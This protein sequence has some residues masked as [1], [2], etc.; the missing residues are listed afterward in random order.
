MSGRA[1]K[2]ADAFAYARSHPWI[3]VEAEMADAEHFA[4]RAAVLEASMRFRLSETALR[5]LAHTADTGREQ[6]PEL[7]ARA[8]E[9]FAGLAQV[10][11]AIALLPRFAGNADLIR[12]FDTY[13]SEAVLHSSPQSFR[14]KALRKARKLSPGSDPEAHADAFG[15]RRVIFEELADGMSCVHLFASTADAHAIKRRLTSTAK[16]TQRKSR[17]GASRDERTRDQ[18]RAD[19][20]VAWLRGAGTPTAVKTKVFVTVPLD[21][22]TP[23]AQATVRRQ[24]ADASVDTSAIDIATEPQLLGSGPIDATIA[25]QL[26]LD[27]GQF[28]RVITDPVSGVILDMDRRSRLVTRAQREWLMLTHHLCVRDGCNRVAIDA[29]IDHW[30]EYHG[31]ERG[32][33]NISNLHPLCEP[34]HRM[35]SKTKLRYRRRSDGSVGVASPTG[36]ATSVPWWREPRAVP[37]EAPF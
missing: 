29:E 34:D 3:Y 7:W 14:A 4:E 6:L 24:G 1:A 21:R 2:L 18:I 8:R 13:A 16:H 33:T 31:P 26:L 9:G 32:P 22:L 11:A 19:L 27:A 35:K 37:G 36:F 23:E 30:Q 15:R 28:T 25:S 20:M 5:G 12:Q 17:P 10:D